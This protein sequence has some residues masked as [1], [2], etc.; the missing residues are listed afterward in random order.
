MTERKTKRPANQ[1]DPQHDSDEERTLALEL[2][3]L[4]AE[5]DRTV[6]RA[7]LMYY[8][9]VTISATDSTQR[10]RSPQYGTGGATPGSP[11]TARSKTCA[12]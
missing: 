11:W 10:P 1:S 2:T 5:L 8:L 4:F 3:G 9:F 6:A 7:G 12:I